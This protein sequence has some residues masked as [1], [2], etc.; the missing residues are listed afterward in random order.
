MKDCILVGF[1]VAGDHGAIDRP[2]EASLLIFGSRGGVTAVVADH[3]VIGHYLGQLKLF[4]NLL[5]MQFLHD[6]FRRLEAYLIFG[7]EKERVSFLAVGVNSAVLL[8]LALHSIEEL[9]EREWFFELAFRLFI[10]RY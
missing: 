10:G 8:A 3:A 9:L 2:E 7:A 4:P 1:L 5:F 6:L